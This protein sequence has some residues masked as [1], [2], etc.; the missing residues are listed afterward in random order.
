MSAS[1]GERVLDWMFRRQRQAARLDQDLILVHDGPVFADVG[2]SLLLE[3]ERWRVAHVTGELTLRDALPDADRLIALVPAS[4]PP[5]P[6]DIAG[7]AYLHRI[8]DVRAEDLVAAVSRRFCE[9]LVDETLAKAVFDSLDT[10]RA[11]EGRWSLVDLVSAREVRAVL[12]GAELGAVRLDRERDVQL[13][14]RWI[15]EGAPRFRAGELVRAALHEALGRPGIWLG[16][17][18]TEGSLELLCTA[19]ALLPSAEGAKHA[20]PLP[21]LSD[22]EQ[23]QLV[24]LV[25]S[26]LHEVWRTSRERALEMLLRAERTA[27]ENHLDLDPEKHRLLRVPL[28]GRLI[29]L[30]TDCARGEPPED[31]VI[32]ALSRNLHAS[33]HRE[34]IAF[35]ANLAR[36]ARFQKL[37][38]PAGSEPIDAWGKLAKLHVAFADLAHRRA[39]RSLESVPRWLADPSRQVLDSWLRRRDALSREFAIAL[40]ASWASVAASTDPKNPLA[41]HQITR[42]VIRR[43]LDDGSRVLL[44]V[45]DGCDLTSFVEILETLPREARIGLA[46]PD[47]RSSA[48][49]ADLDRITAFGVAISPLPTVTSH[50]RRA[51]FAGE[52]PG[53]TALDE[54]ESSAANATGDQLAWSRNTALGEVPR[55]LFLKGDLGAD[56]QPLIDALRAKKERVVAA[57]WNAVDDSLS[58]K[59]TTP[60]EPWSVSAL[61]AGSLEVW[62]TAIDEGWA[63]VVTADHG[64]TPFVAPDRKESPAALGQRFAAEAH[65]GT[66]AFQTGPLP[67]KPLH[68]L[69]RFGAWFGNQ[70]RGFHGGA[71][72]EE[73]VVPLAFLGRVRDD[74]E[75]RVVHPSWWWSDEG[76]SQSPELVPLEVAPPPRAALPAPAPP[77]VREEVTSG[78][79]DDPRFDALTREEKLVV[80]LLRENQSA[81]LLVIAQRLGKTPMRASGFM[82]QLSR[83]LFEIGLG[84]I[85][86]EVLP[87]N[88]RLYKFS[89]PDR[90]NR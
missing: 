63:V 51:L 81:R 54:T 28:E 70:R 41:L 73:V 76:L 82:Q 17:A 38:V 85:T 7:R 66:V 29:K 33:D 12:V 49:H 8:L 60:R 13:L 27:R 68:L 61:G 43:L 36:L 11:T 2:P 78:L 58:S 65:E 46:L 5:P 19:G 83:K 86:V 37:P 80:H 75:G 25:E 50:A 77:V 84:S 56:G 69:T 39:R 40:S 62:K 72:I 45:L 74:Q 23:G 42:C 57:V 53:N 22:S 14:A 4:F 31:A 16:W 35:V 52:I 26:A 67:R 15:L 20:P 34:S 71:A 9:A 44:L 6:A 24:E 90:G 48:L 55:R 32:Q 1:L 10:L 59:E 87:D 79:G 47:V 21:F 88:E 30:A 64:H 89:S 3:G 18:L